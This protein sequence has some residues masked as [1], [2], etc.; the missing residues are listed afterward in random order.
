M[1]R[2][3]SPATQKLLLESILFNLHHCPRA[4]TFSLAVEEK[5]SWVVDIPK[6]LAASRND[7]LSMIDKEG[8]EDTLANMD[9][10]NSNVLSNSLDEIDTHCHF[11]YLV[12]FLKHVGSC[13]SVC[14][15]YLYI[16]LYH[17][18]VQNP[19]ECRRNPFLEK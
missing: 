4:S 13:S 12:D 18:F 16:H 1:V 7:H 9:D 6:I 2:R 15:H 5:A 14:Y 17:C 8:D 11:S 19:F 3:F 10:P